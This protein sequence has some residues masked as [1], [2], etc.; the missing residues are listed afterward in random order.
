MHPFAPPMTPY[1]GPERRRSLLTSRL[2]CLMLDEV[3]YGLLLLSA[4]HHVLH[5]NQAARQALRGEHPLLLLGGELRARRPQDVAP[6]HEALAQASGRGLRRM[7]SLG[8]DNQ[9]VSISVV[10][11]E[12]NPAWVGPRHGVLVV[13]GR[14]QVSGALAVQGFARAHRLSPGEEQ[15]L[16]GLCEGMA[17]SQIAEL[18]GVKIATVRTQIAN[19]RAKTGTATIRDLVS[20]VACLPPLVGALRLAAERADAPALA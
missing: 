12:A 13:L 4:D 18:N 7:L 9:H 15:V 19:I 20:R 8:E 3:D 2:F 6:L 5:A 14:Q 1:T 11:L 10:P 17:P 16:R